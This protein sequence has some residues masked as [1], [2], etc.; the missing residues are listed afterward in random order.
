MYRPELRA[1]TD[2]GKI[3]IQVPGAAAAPAKASIQAPA[4]LDDKAAPATPVADA[5]AR[6]TGWSNRMVTTPEVTSDGR[7][8]GVTD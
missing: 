1:N 7:I 5:T 8:V 4:A 2:A 6:P 3:E